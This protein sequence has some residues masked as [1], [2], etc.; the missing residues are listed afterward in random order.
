M[1][2][3]ERLHFPELAALG[4]LRHAFVGRAAGVEVSV[5]REEAIRRLAEF[6]DAA[7]RAEGFVGE[8]VLAEQVH[9]SRVV[10][11]TEADAVAV[12][13]P[14]A[15]GL[16]T[17]RPGLPLAIYVAD[18]CAVYLADPVRRAIGLVHAGRKG[19]EL[20]ILPEAIR[21]LGETYGSRP[22]DLLVQLSPCIRPPCYDVD[23]AALLRE[24][25]RDCGVGE[26]F[27][28]GVCTGCDLG[29]WYSYRIEKGRTGRMLALLALR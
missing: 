1:S 22:S 24:Q 27:D 4:W 2:T 10:P 25:A 7:R 12:P 16:L 13:V 11:V 9:G 14:G 23:F 17:D 20:G 8:P 26:V 15:D 18:C 21:L 19:A 28:C 5:E 29:R 3:P 6:H